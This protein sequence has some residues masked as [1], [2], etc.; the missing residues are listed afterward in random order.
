[1]YHWY[2]I[3]CTI[4]PYHDLMRCV[5][6]FLDKWSVWL[7]QRYM[8][9]E[10]KSYQYIYL[11]TGKYTF[12][13]IYMYLYIYIRL[14]CMISIMLH[15]S[16]GVFVYLYKSYDPQVEKLASWQG[17]IQSPSVMVTLGRTI[18]L[19]SQVQE[20]HRLLVGDMLVPWRVW[21]KPMMTQSG[22][23]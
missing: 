1:M 12:I 4:V 13:C 19:G 22:S 23:S 11:Y 17:D 10:W 20:N 15:D 8:I 5:F 18:L 16:S 6:F 2:A 21:F 14:L 3:S 9:H 7:S